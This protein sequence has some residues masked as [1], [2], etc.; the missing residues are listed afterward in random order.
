LADVDPNA[1]SP[2]GVHGGMLRE[3]KGRTRSEAGDEATFEEFYRTE[4]PRLVRASLV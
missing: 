4:C 2:G 3:L 1:G